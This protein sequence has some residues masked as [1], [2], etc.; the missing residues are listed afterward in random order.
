MGIEEI[1]K[2]LEDDLKSGIDKGDLAEYVGTIVADFLDDLA[3]EIAALSVVPMSS[4]YAVR[5]YA[6]RV[7]S[8][9]A[10]ALRGEA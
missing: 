3:G 4:P 2:I 8:D 7:V 6:F 1:H 5:E 10:Q 9:Q